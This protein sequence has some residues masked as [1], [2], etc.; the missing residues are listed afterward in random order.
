[1][2]LLIAASQRKAGGC[3]LVT[4]FAAISSI[5]GRRR[6]DEGRG[7]LKIEPNCNSSL[8]QCSVSSRFHGAPAGICEPYAGLTLNT[9]HSATWPAVSPAYLRPALRGNGPG[10]L[11]LGPW[12]R[13]T[14]PVLTQQRS[15]TVGEGCLGNSPG[16]SRP[17]RLWDALP[18]CLPPG[19][20]PAR[21][22]LPILR[23]FLSRHSPPLSSNALHRCGRAVSTR[24]QAAPGAYSAPLS[25]SSVGFGALNT[26]REKGSV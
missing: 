13:E 20:W 23:S 17:S 3:R 24:E 25:S 16:W 19:E 26:E 10:R 12:S 8:W 7:T 1:M 4:G 21:A 22:L 15:R 2:E 18:A 11:A 6:A 14:S 9:P 5:G